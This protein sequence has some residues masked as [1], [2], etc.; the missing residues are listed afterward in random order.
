[1][2]SVLCLNHLETIPPNPWS[3]ETLSSMKSVSG[4]KKAGDCRGKKL[5]WGL[6]GRGRAGRETKLKGLWGLSSCLRMM[7]HTHS[8]S[9]VKKSNSFTE[10]PLHS[11]FYV[12]YF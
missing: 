8:L 6:G 5:G 10:C 4:A 12:S 9:R 7:E 11:M 2:I 1:M 3:M